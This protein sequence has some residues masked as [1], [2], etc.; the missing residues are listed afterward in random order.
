MQYINVRKPKTEFSLKARFL[1]KDTGG[2][3]DNDKN[4]YYMFFKNSM[5]SVQEL[6]KN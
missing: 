6:H 3:D 5:A 4:P 2:Y 1:S